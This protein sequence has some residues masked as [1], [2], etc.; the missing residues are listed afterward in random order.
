MCVRAHVGVF[1]LCSKFSST[2]KIYKKND[3]L[4]EK[5]FCS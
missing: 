5:Y 1:L 3:K 2:G 4:K